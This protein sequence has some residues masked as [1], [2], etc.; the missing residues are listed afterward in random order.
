MNFSSQFVHIAQRNIS[1][2]IFFDSLLSDEDLSKLLCT[3]KDMKE[4]VL[5]WKTILPIQEYRIKQ[6]MTN[7]EFFKMLFYY[8]G[9]INSLTIP[10]CSS[11]TFDGYLLLSSFCVNLSELIIKQSSYSFVS[12]LKQPVFNRSFF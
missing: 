1:S 8:S 3:C 7:D 9:N 12:L 5:K 10:F 2:E 11:L 6:S 4:V